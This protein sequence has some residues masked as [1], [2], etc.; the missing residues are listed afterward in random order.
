MSYLQGFEPDI[1]I[2]YS[3]IDNQPF[4]S[5]QKRWVSEFHKNLETRIRILLGRDVEIW[6]DPKLKG[7]DVFSDEIRG[8]VSDTA[9]LVTIISPG[10][11]HSEWCS[12]ELQ[13]FIDGA[14]SGGGWHAEGQSRIVKV[15]KTPVPLQQQSSGLRSLLGY[16][17]YRIE[18]ETE[19]VREFLLDPSPEAR[20]SYWTKLDEVAQDVARLF[21][22]LQ[23]GDK[24]HRDPAKVIYV[25]ETTSDLKD[26][27]ESLTRELVAHGY[28]P[29]PN[30]PLPLNSTDLPNAVRR[31]LEQSCL[32]VHLI[33]ARYGIV[34]EGESRSLI[35]VQN[36]VAAEHFNGSAS[37]LIWVPKNME[38]KEEQQARDSAFSL[39]R[40]PR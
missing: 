14:A 8:K 4:G 5:G 34:P 21:S 7:T 36:E 13:T 29:V 26:K 25:A 20:N 30:G 19:R 1:F 6:R 24:Q 28:H 16:E 27:R 10:Y 17:F 32:S 23:S 31:N 11:L 38:P 37:R 39:W 15:L 33:G 22:L 18:P 35:Q 3:H 9:V 40:S 12:R 2:S